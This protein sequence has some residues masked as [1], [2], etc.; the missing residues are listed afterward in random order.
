MKKQLLRMGLF[1]CLLIAIFS[2]AASASLVE[3]VGEGE[4]DWENQVIRVKGFGVPRPGTVG[5]QGRLLAERAAKA[6]AYRNAAAV[7]SGV[8]VSSETYV[9]DYVT[10]SD[11][12][13][14]QIE[15][16]IQGG[17][18]EDAKHSPDGLCEIT[19]ILPL[20]GINGLARLLSEQAKNDA[21]KTSPPVISTESVIHQPKVE[22]SPDE[23]TYSGVIIDARGLG[24]KPA[25]YPQIFS[26]DGFLLYGPTTV[27]VNSP[28]ITTMIAYSRSHEKALAM[29]R[30][31]KNPL[32]IR[33]TSIVKADNGE[34]T[35]IVLGNEATQLLLQADAK[36]AILSRAAVVMII[37]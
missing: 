33:A 28:G 19:L 14:N 26:V 29:E 6:D 11:I 32:Q 30:I 24:V 1:G 25:L 22:P 37:D 2:L 16:F 3:K 36:N 35:D 18:F 7:I 9:K 4:I 34:T 15:G 8:R 27:D 21:A 23:L 13:L 10:E 12:I 17:M 31:G 5:P 20:G